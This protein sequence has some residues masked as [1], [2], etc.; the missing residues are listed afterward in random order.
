MGRQV[1]C[2]AIQ[3]DRRGLNGDPLYFVQRD[4]FLAAVV[5]HGGAGELVVGDVL[6]G[7][8]GGREEGSWELFCVGQSVVME[9]LR[10]GSC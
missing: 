6:G 4:L 7:L 2:R 10:S 9:G 3:P 5:E 1:P 8:R